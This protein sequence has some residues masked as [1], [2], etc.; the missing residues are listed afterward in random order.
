ML[1]TA[2]NITLFGQVDFNTLACMVAALGK[3]Q[4][5]N[6]QINV[7]TEYHFNAFTIH[8]LRSGLASRRVYGQ[9]M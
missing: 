8:R 3:L 2:G 4:S 6:S 7:Q 1:L 9:A 5:E